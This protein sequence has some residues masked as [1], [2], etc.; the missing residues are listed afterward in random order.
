MTVERANVGEDVPITATFTEHDT[1][2]AVDGDSAPTITITDNF[3]GM[4]VISAVAMTSGDVGTYSYE[5]DTSADANG[6]GRYVI[7]I[8]GEFSSLT[9]I[10]TDQIRL[11]D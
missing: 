4:E 9:K 5:W 7:E 3:D 2:N 10:V 6:A 1:G 8:T 11:V